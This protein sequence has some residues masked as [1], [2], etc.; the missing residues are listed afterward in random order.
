MNIL[1]LKQLD[2]QLF[3][4]LSGANRWPGLVTACRYLSRTGDGY[5]YP[6]VGLMAWC[7]FPERGTAFLIAT[8][9]AFLIERPI[10]WLLKNGFKRNR[11]AQAN[12]GIAAVVTPSDKFSLP[13][14]HTAAAFVM[15][16]MLSTFFAEI[17]WL[18]YGWACL[19]GYSRVML[20]VHFPADVVCGALLGITVATAVISLV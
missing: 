14:G 2:E 3:L 16:T 4:R 20:R 1:S 15:A 7:L 5:W 17:Q 18:A 12:L 10:Y 13:S 11:P 19:V 6:L 8:L 9:T